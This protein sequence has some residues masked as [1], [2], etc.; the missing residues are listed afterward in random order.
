MPAELVAVS[1]R[2]R[3][4]LGRC[5]RPLA[6]ALV[7]AFLVLIGVLAPIEGPDLPEPLQS[8]AETRVA[9]A[10]INPVVPGTPDSCPTT[11][12]PWSPQPLDTDF[13]TAAECILELPPC[14][15][16]PWDISQFLQPSTQYPEFCETSVVSTDINY[17][18]CVNA[19]GAVVEDS[20]TVCRVIQNAIC[21]SGVRV[22]P[23]NCRTVERRTWTCPLDY[24]PRN[25]FNTCFK[26]PVTNYTNHPACGPGAPTFAILDCANYVGDDFVQ[27]PTLVP[28]SAFDPVGHPNTFLAT[29]NDYWCTYDS[30]LLDLDCYPPNP[31][32]T[33]AL[34]LCIKRASRT[35]GCSVLAKSIACRALQ[36]E[37]AAGNIQLEDVRAANCEPCVILP[38]QP[39]PA[40]CPDDLTDEPQQEPRSR[41]RNAAFEA[42]LREERDIRIGD[43]RCFPVA[44]GTIWPISY[45]G[46]EPLA[47]HPNC[48]SLRSR[49]PNPSPG[50]L[51][52]ASSH[53]SQ[54]AVVNTPVAVTINDIPTT[55]S[56]QGYL[57]RFGFNIRTSS[58][59]YADYPEPD[60][61][62]IDSFMRIWEDVNNTVTYSSVANMARRTRSCYLYYVPLF[63]LKVRELWPDNLSD[64]LEIQ[65]LFGADS[66]DWWNSIGTVAERERRTNAQGFEWWNN[67]TPAEQADRIDEMTHEVSCDNNTD[68][69]VWCR[70]AAG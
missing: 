32:C 39:I 41:S 44:G 18:A 7:G 37:F 67:L 14:L 46:G 8:L 11:P 68:E 40:A 54:L 13:L 12:A 20:G 33:S 23:D 4:R 30:S 60:P 25:E 17:P 70:V 36:A 6:K 52:W 21:P 66:L 42:I 69:A 38:F 49:C 15:A 28:C 31:P 9:L 65:D 35:G 45:P 47:D 22:S 59:S 24:V 62:L 26:T 56:T 43:S 27:D 10:Q 64:Y 5:L 19:T 51:T 63:K 58:R 57:Y 2:P 3:A 16:T 61:N 55:Y 48:E 34:A 1:T 29:A 53:F 50:R